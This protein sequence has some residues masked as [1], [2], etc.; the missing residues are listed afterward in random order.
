MLRSHRNP[1]FPNFPKVIAE[2]CFYRYLDDWKTRPVS[3][4]KR[5][6]VQMLVDK[7]GKENGKATANRTVEL[8]TLFTENP[9]GEPEF[10]NYD[11]AQQIFESLYMV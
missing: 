2:E 8:L 7:L 1:T 10:A 11:S 4:I 6:E 3:S 5:S 9:W